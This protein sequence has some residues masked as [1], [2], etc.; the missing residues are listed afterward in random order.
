MEYDDFANEDILYSIKCVTQEETL[1]GDILYSRNA[2]IRCS[3]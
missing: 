1:S 2:L 3:I